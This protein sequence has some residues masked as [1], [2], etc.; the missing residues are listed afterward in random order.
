MSDIFDIPS[1]KQT[2]RKPFRP[3]CRNCRTNR[4]IIP[5][6]YSIEI[7]DELLEKEQNKE[8]IL[9]GNARSQDAPNWY[10]T[11]CEGLFLR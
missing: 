5:V 9:G 4:Y 8:I 7:T 2:R 6:L 3:R 10:C 11:K 1:R